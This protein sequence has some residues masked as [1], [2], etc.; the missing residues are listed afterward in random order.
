MAYTWNFDKL[1]KERHEEVI[2]LVKQ[3][4]G[5]KLMLIHNQYLLSEELYCCP[6]QDNMVLNWFKYGIET[7]QIKGNGQSTS[8]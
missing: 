4:A 5:G 8:E 1:P 7:G 6:V 2:S 3:G